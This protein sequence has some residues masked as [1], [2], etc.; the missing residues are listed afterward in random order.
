MRRIPFEI[1]L[2]TLVIAAHLYVVFLPANSLVNWFHSDD[3][4][5]YFKVAQNIT[6]GRGITFDRLG[7]DSGFHPLWMILITPIFALARFDLIV[8]LRLVVLLSA[9]LS[10]GTAVL[11]Y[12][13]SK[14]ILHPYAAAF[15]AFF[16]AFHPLIHANV[17][18]MGLESALSAFMIALLLY[19]LL[20]EQEAKAPS[21]LRWFLTGLVGALTVLARLDNVFIVLIAGIWITF[22]PARLR[23]LLV[24]DLVLI[25]LGVLAVNFIRVGIG[26]PAIPYMLSSQVMVLVTLIVRVPVYYLFGLYS[27]SPGSISL[28]QQLW[29]AALAS[30]FAT[31][32]IASIMLLLQAAHLFPGF[33]RIVIAYEAAYA[34]AFVV[35]TRAAVTL[36]TRSRPPDEPLRWAS[37]LTRAGFF[38]IPIGLILIA[39]MGSSYLYFGTFMPVSGQ[40]KRWW[41]TLYTVYGHPIRS[42]PEMIGFFNL[43]PWDLLNRMIRFPASLSAQ[44]RLVLWG[45]PAALLLLRPTYRTHFIRALHS[46]AIFPLFAGGFIQMLAYTGTSYTHM[47]VW[48]WVAQFILIGLVLGILLDSFVKWIQSLPHTQN[49]AG[50]WNPAAVLT[51]A[52]CVL[53]FTVGAADVMKRMPLR[54]DPDKAEAYLLEARLVAE[55]TEPGALIGFTGGGTTAYFIQDRTIVNLDGLMNTYEYYQLLKKWRAAEYLDKI[56][57]QYVVARDY[58]I[59]K[60]EPYTQFEGRLEEISL[61]G[62]NTFF[63][64][65]SGGE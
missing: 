15:I 2:A 31:G 5:Y 14:R 37:V 12:R 53:V 4:F 61:I 33:P 34:L 35:L 65:K 45:L 8:P 41:G 29:R 62:E 22:P 19:R 52:L 40:I 50:I 13:L 26:P 27:V 7:R 58:V 47:R 28:A 17:T 18:E 54:V 60:S 59:T 56:G 38:F 20:Q 42:I 57:L 43:G 49:R 64:W 32:I 46:L 1:W 48:Y 23:Y 11:L 16:W 3:G 51:A 39:Y 44:L 30:L 63:R 36:L 24:L 10:A 9:L 25:I 21:Y 55:N 6:E